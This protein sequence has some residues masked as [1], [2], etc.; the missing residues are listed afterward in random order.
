MSEN[1]IQVNNKQIITFLVIAV[2]VVGGFIG[3]IAKASSGGQK[4][5]SGVLGNAKTGNTRANDGFLGDGGETLSAE[6]D[7]VLIEESKVSDGNLHPFNY[8]SESQ[9]KNIYFFV[10]KAPDG[11]YRAAANAC[12]VCYDS[13]KGFRQVG[14]RI[15]CENC[16]TTYS[17]SQIALQKGGCNPRPIDKDVNVINGQLEIALS[18]IEKTA[19]LF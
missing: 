9:G 17:K 13:K 4:D 3:V 8:Y 6:G 1:Q 10:L 14:D 5:A 15:L 18:D 7:R 11:T 16:R 12:E 2:A 19:D